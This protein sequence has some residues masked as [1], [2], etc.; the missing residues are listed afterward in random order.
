MNAA[1]LG[2]GK[3]VTSINMTIFYLI[4][5]YVW[6]VL[7]CRKLSRDSSYGGKTRV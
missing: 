7:M 1:A 4:L 5:Y 2:F 3:L 6:I